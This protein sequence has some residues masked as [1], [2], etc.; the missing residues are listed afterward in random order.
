MP[1]QITK[2]FRGC[3][4]GLGTQDVGL[5]AGSC[6]PEEHLGCQVWLHGY[7]ADR[8][9]L[10]RRL[11][12]DCARTTNCELLA[13]AFRKWGHALQAHVLGEYAAVIFDLHGQVALLCHDALGLAPL[14]YAP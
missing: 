5:S 1:P 14:F 2:G 4:K 12:L 9:E 13:Y 11:G 3:L 6:R 8:K 10:G 7:I